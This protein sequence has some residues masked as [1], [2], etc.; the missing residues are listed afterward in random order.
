MLWLWYY[1]DESLSYKKR[2]PEEFYLDNISFPSRLFLIYDL[3][4]E[5][6]ACRPDGEQKAQIHASVHKQRVDHINPL[7]HLLSFK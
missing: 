4:T 7:L 3:N 5:K 1:R 2:H 6:T